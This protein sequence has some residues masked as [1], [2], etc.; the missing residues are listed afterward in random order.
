MASSTRNTQQNAGLPNDTIPEL[1]GCFTGDSLRYKKGVFIFKI[2]S[3]YFAA[4]ESYHNIRTNRI[5]LRCRKSGIKDNCRFMVYLKT[6]KFSDPISNPRSIF[7]QMDNFFV[8]SSFGIHTC[9]GYDTVED[10]RGFRHAKTPKTKNT[11][12]K[13]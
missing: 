7:Y 2:D 5:I 10:A 13:Y 6:V 11:R 3:K 9:E 4:K 8:E 1:V 12:Q